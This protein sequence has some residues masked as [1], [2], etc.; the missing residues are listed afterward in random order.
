[1]KAIADIILVETAE[2]L[3]AVRSLFEEYWSSFGFTP[4]FQ[5]FS[6]ELDGLPGAYV[7]PGGRL[8][9]AWA[10]GRP[11]GCIALRPADNGRGELKRLYVRPIHRGRGLGRLLL[12]WIVAEA[13]AIGYTELIGDSLPVMRDA[14]VLYDRSGFERSQP[15]GPEGTIYLRLKL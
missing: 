4:C 12:D 11:A 5:N 8:A 7:P 3:A 2:D 6:E 1:M 13:R 14:L 15:E 10:H 9:I